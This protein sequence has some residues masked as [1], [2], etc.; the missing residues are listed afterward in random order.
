M[1]WRGWRRDPRGACGAILLGAGEHNYKDGQWN[2]MRAG[3]GAGH[4]WLDDY[5]G[6]LIAMN[7]AGNFQLSG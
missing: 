3:G 2:G 6:T 1:K 7:A 4:A 5:S